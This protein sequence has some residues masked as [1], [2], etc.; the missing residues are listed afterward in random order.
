[1]PYVSPRKHRIELLT[2]LDQQTICSQRGVLCKVHTREDNSVDYFCETHDTS[3]C[4]VCVRGAHEQCTLVT[5]EVKAAESRRTL[6]EQADLLRRQE[7]L[8]REV[9][10]RLMD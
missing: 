10:Q 4:L 9:S 2:A 5:M 3:L 7:R 1:M 8:L 6:R